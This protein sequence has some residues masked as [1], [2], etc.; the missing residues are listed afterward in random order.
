MIDDVV[1]IAS[2]ICLVT[3]LGSSPGMSTLL[4][5]FNDSDFITRSYW[6]ANERDN[7]KTDLDINIGIIGGKLK[8]SCSEMGGLG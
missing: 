5:V 6:S 3:V 4:P 2:A 7:R 8:S 1:V